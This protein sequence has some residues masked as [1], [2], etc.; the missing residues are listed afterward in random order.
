[1]TGHILFLPDD[2]TGGKKS[3]DHKHCLNVLCGPWT[4]EQWSRGMY[5]TNVEIFW[6]IPRNQ[7]E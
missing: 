6:C 7:V 2:G 5:L 4:S 3:R 1:M